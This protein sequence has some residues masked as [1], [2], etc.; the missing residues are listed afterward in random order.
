MKRRPDSVLVFWEQIATRE[1]ALGLPSLQ[2]APAFSPGERE[3]RVWTGL[4]TEPPFDELVR[5]HVRRTRV[6]G[7]RWHLW[8]FRPLAPD[9]DADERKDFRIATLADRENWKLRVKYYGCGPRQ[10]RDGHGYCQATLAPGETWERLLRDLDSLGV[11]TLPD[12]TWLEPPRE[13]GLDGWHLVV[14][15][16][17]A[18]AYRT[19]SYWAPDTLS[20]QPEVRTAWRFIQ[21]IAQAFERPSRKR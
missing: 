1:R 4:S 14:E 15:E 19:Y 2:N 17:T 16:R 10:Y 8:P 13:M 11:R 18:D 5:I 12:E 7:Q 6:S 3:L 20:A 9:A 21:R